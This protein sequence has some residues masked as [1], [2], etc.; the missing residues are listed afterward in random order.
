MESGGRQRHREHGPHILCPVNAVE[1]SVEEGW[2]HDFQAL[3][4]NGM[5]ANRGRTETNRN[6]PKREDLDARVR[7]E[8]TMVRASRPA[9]VRTT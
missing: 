6:E 9:A 5:T 3:G 8:R 7:S 4:S 1:G 2:I